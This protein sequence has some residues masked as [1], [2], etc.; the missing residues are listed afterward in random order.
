MNKVIKIALGAALILSVGATS[1]FA[2]ADKG[3][4]LFTKKLKKACGITGAA[5]AGKHTQAEWAEIKENGKGA[6]E[7]KKICPAATDADLKEENL[8]HY[9]DFFHEFGSDSGNVPAC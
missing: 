9:L 2:S 4:K 6:E 3:Q 5:M 7:I 1:S 8:E